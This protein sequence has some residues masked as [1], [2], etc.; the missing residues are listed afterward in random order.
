MQNIEK[1]F[2]SENFDT[3]LLEE[4]NEEVTEMGQVKITLTTTRNQN[5]GKTNNN[6]TTID[7]GECEDILRSVYSIPDNEFLYMIKKE[8]IQEGYSI[9]N[10]RI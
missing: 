6:L 10:Y 3:T 4:G 9:I 7:I 8:V 1:G 5:K 2:I